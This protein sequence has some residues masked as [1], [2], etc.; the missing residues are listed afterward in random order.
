MRQPENRRREASLGR[1]GRAQRGLRG[2]RPALRDGDHADRRAQAQAEGV[3]RGHLRQGR[4]GDRRPVAQRV[5]RDASGPQR[6]DLGQ[7]GRV[8]RG[9][10]PEARR[11][12]QVGVR[13]GRSGLPGAPARRALRGVLLGVRPVGQP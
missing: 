11:Q 13:R 12:P 8:Q 6:R 9:P 4:H 2:A 3:G 7:A 1:R 10:V 5:V